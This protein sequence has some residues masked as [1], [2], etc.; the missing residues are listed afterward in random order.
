LY[1]KD[2]FEMMIAV[3]YQ[4]DGI[5]L[6]FPEQYHH[7]LDGPFCEDSDITGYPKVPGVYKCKV[8]FW[9]SQGYD[10]DGY[11]HD[12]ESDWKFKIINS[13]SLVE[14]N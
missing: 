6:K 8:E 14:L 5:V 10:V 2:T 11:P 12:G 3:D 7:L 4:G 9:Y 1:L 13:E